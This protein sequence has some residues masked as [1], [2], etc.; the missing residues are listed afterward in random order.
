MPSNDKKIN[1]IQSDKKKEEI[2]KKEPTKKDLLELGN[3][4]ANYRKKPLLIM[5]YCD[6]AGQIIPYDVKHIYSKK[7]IY[8]SAR[9]IWNEM[10]ELKNN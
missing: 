9:L 2:I 5:Y 7:G 1:K 8:S 4:I 3:Q 6:D 10:E